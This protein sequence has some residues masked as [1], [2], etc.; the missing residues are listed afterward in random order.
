[1]ERSNTPPLPYL[2]TVEPVST[3]KD[4]MEQKSRRSSLPSQCPLPL[5]TKDQVLSVLH[6]CQGATALAIC[7][8]LQSSYT[9]QKKDVN[10]LLY[11]LKEDGVATK[12]SDCPPVWS[13]TAGFLA[14]DTL[15]RHGYRK[16]CTVIVDT[17]NVKHIISNV[18]NYSQDYEI[19]AVGTF[20]GISESQREGYRGL[21]RWRAVSSEFRKPEIVQ[22]VVEA[23]TVMNRSVPPETLYICSMNKALHQLI[24]VGKDRGVEVIFAESWEQLALYVE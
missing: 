19:I 14:A 2:N 4:S 18:A 15:T 3:L 10:R 17:G 12:T 1:M 24:N 13:P 9:C 23:H 22:L 16:R 21:V 8:H 20:A 7:R 11:T 5:P 6:S